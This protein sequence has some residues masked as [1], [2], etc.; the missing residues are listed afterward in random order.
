MYIESVMLFN[1]LIL[2][3][4]LLLCLWSFP[5]SIRVFASES[6][7]PIRWPQ[8][9]SFSFNISPSNE[10]NIHSTLKVEL[11]GLNSLKSKGLSRVF[12][13]T[14]IQKHQFFS[15][16]PSLCFSSQISTHDYWKNHSLWLYRTLSAKW[17]LC[18]LIWCVG[19][20][21]LSFQGV[22]AVLNRSVVSDSLRPHGL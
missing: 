10:L 1:Y 19:L 13:S 7:L 8:Y 21:Q 9:W 14:T 6:A 12:F 20:S 17:Y 16:Q 4:P 5:A 22:H 15:A 3:Q 11:T 18:F 2:C